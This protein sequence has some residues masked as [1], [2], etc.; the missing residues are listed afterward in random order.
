[1]NNHL[2]ECKIDHLYYII[3]YL[4]YF[5]K[6]LLKGYYSELFNTLL[7]L[8]RMRNSFMIQRV[9]YQSK[10]IF[11]IIINMIY[12]NPYLKTEE[13]DQG[14]IVMR[15]ETLFTLAP[16]YTDKELGEFLSYPYAGDIGIGK[17]HYNILIKY[18]G[19]ECQLFG[20]ISRTD[21][22]DKS[23]KFEMD[24]NNFFSYINTVYKFP[25]VVATSNYKK[26]IH[27]PT[28]ISIFE[29][30]QETL[31]DYKDVYYILDNYGLKYDEYNKNELINLLYQIEQ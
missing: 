19:V 28:L 27:I 15:E 5:E 8:C 30:S 20:M 14:I 7:V 29:N 17:Y 23:K 13:I 31:L 9:D 2:F 6:N 4:N 18:K 24:L 11:D 1:M 12:N 25:L 26:R 10:N 22:T 16:N 3:D 21:G